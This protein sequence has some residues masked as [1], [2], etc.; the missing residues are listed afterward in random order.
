MQ[1]IVQPEETKS[2][3]ACVGVELYIYTLI[4]YVYES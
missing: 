4:M 2:L 3:L 1:K